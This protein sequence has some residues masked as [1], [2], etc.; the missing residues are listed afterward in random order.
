MKKMLII[1]I[2]LTSLTACTPKPVKGLF[3]PLPTQTIRTIH[4]V[5]HGW[6]TGLVIPTALVKRH[7]WPEIESFSSFRFVEAGWGDEGFYR[8]ETITACL[9]G[10][11]VFWPTASVLHLAGFNNK[12]DTYFPG[13]GIISVNLSEEGFDAMCSFIS[14]TFLLD[15]SSNPVNLGHGIY[16]ESRFFRAVGNYYFPKTC[17]VWTGKALRQAGCPIF[18]WLCIRSRGVMEQAIMFGDELNKSPS[19]KLNQETRSKK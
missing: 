17:N 4:V 6:H 8:A 7:N 2:I 11:A 9:A 3:P 10:K 15:E 14:R 5:S 1:F 13:S 18:S 19:I 16:G 12:V